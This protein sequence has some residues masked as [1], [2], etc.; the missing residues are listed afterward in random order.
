MIFAYYFMLIKNICRAYFPS[1]FYTANS[2]TFLLSCT[3][4]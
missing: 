2:K 3:F 4:T 1:R